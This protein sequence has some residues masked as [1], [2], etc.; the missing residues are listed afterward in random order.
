MPCCPT[1]KA[2]SDTCVWVRLTA[3]RREPKASHRHICAS[4][5][6]WNPIQ[7]IILARDISSRDVLVSRCRNAV[8]RSQTQ[9]SEPGLSVRDLEKQCWDDTDKSFWLLTLP[10]RMSGYFSDPHLF[11]ELYQCVYLET[12]VSSCNRWTEWDIIGDGGFCCKLQENTFA[13]SVS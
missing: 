9:L 3:L 1:V 12:A 13:S 8:K 6:A 2:G 10:L 11:I 7:G 5:E 4:Y